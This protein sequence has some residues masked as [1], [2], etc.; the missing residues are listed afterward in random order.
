MPRKRGRLIVVE[1]ID[2]SGKSTQIQLLRRWLEARGVKVFFTEWNSSDLVRQATKR[3]KKKNLLTPTTF[4][5]LHAT[6]FA[7]RLT[8]SI[9]PYLKAGITVLAD[10]YIYTAFARDIARGVDR[11]WVRDLYAFAGKPDAAFYFRVP[12]DVAVARIMGARAKIKFYEAG[13]DLGLSADPVESFRLF[14]GRVLEEY[15]RL[16]GEYG[17]RVIDGTRSIDAQQRQVR[18]QVSRLF[19]HPAAEAS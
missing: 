2:G 14:Q 19:D 8:Y 16:S 1:G 10:R 18:D 9:I 11:R 5:L 4:S 7:D 6:D 12:I 15:D 13:M 3:G 17:F